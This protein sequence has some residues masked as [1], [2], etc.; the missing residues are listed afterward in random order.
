MRFFVPRAAPVQ[1]T[2]WTA[3]PR[4]TSPNPDAGRGRPSDRDLHPK[5]ANSRESAVQLLESP[6]SDV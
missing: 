2:R 4:P 1:P 6:V 5:N 3:F